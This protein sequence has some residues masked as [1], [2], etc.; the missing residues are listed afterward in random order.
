WGQGDTAR[1]STSPKT[2]L[3]EN[4]LWLASDKHVVDVLEQI[5]LGRDVP[6]AQIA[7]AWVLKHPVISSLLVGPTKTRHLVDAV[8]A[9]DI[10]LSDDEISALEDPYVPRTP[11]YFR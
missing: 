4:A 2:D 9:L 5:A 8:A 11:T 3:F 10:E 1:A 7:L 6:M